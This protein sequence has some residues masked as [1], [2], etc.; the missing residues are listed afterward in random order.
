MAVYT[1]AINLANRLIVKKGETST[2]VRSTDGTPPDSTKP[3]TPGTPM[4][5]SHSTPAAWLGSFSF[6]GEGLAAE[7]REFVMIPAKNLTI[8][9]DATTDQLIR[10]S[11]EVWQIIEVRKLDVN[12]EVIFY[13]LEVE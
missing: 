12:G 2:I 6:R 10:A 5:A 4:T 7:G 13:E 8:T 3:W 1:S 9:P 11:G